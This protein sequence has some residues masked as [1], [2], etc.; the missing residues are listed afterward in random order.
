MHTV[1]DSDS[2]LLAIDR[3]LPILAGCLKDNFKPFLPQLM[4]A[5]FRDITRGLDFK[6]VDA[7][8]EELEEKQ[9][10]DSRDQYVK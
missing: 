8:E 9:E 10:D 3:I 5:I 4:D 2:Q 7:V 1:K 6:V